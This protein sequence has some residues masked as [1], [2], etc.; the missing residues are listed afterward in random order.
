MKTYVHII[1]NC[2]QQSMRCR[3]NR[4]M[5]RGIDMTVQQLKYVLMVAEAGSIGSS[6]FR[7][8]FFCFAN[9]WFF[10]KNTCGFAS[11]SSVNTRWYSSSIFRITISMTVQQ[12]KYV[13]MVAEAGSITEAAKKLFISQPSLSNAIKEIE[14]EAGISIF[15]RSSIFDSTTALNCNIPKPHFFAWSKQ[16][17]TSFSPICNPRNWLLTA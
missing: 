8:I 12:L 5:K 15:S 2:N 4:K 13:L 3:A 14:K 17:L 7:E 9:G 16:S 11:N 6:F 1:M 10:C